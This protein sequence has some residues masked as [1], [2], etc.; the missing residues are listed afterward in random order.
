MLLAT[1]FSY[2]RTRANRAMSRATALSRPMMTMRTRAAPQAR[3]NG[4]L[5]VFADRQL[6]L[7]EDERRQRLLRQLLGRAG[8]RVELDPLVDADEQ[9]Q[10]RG[11]AHDAGHTPA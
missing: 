10:R 6:E 5:S 11:L 9:Q 3:L 8:E 4:S 2:P 7:L 1:G